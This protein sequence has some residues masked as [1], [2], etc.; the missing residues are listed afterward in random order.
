PCGTFNSSTI[1]VMIIAI[2]PSLNA[3]KRSLPMTPPC[4]F[5]Q[6]VHDASLL[7]Q[8]AR[9]YQGQ[10]SNLATGTDGSRLSPLYMRKR[11]AGACQFC[12]IPHATDDFRQ[13]CN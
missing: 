1:I 3:A 10:R 5:K 9:H 11:A 12:R 4:L 6:R 13:D 8:T 7:V 2:T